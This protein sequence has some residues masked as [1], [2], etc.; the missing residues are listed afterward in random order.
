M[1]KVQFEKTFANSDNRGSFDLSSLDK[2]SYTR[3]AEIISAA[4]TLDSLGIIGWLT[5]LGPGASYSD[6]IGFGFKNF[7]EYGQPY[8]IHH[9][10]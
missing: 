3:I 10:S 9:R 8:H 4:G 2:S 5:G 1:K 6:S 7:N